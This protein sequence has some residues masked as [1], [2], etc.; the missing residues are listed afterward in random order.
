M[1]DAEGPAQS[2]QENRY[3]EFIQREK[4]AQMVLSRTRTQTHFEI[5]PPSFWHALPSGFRKVSVDSRRYDELFAEMQ[6]FR[7]RVYL[8]D[9]AIQPN[10]LADGR[11]KLNLDEHSWHVLSL[12]SS[13]RICAC[14]RFLEEPN[15]SGFD[16]LWVREAELAF[17]PTQ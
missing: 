12:D 8:S 11:H 3:S 7:G 14:A 16:D 17:S 1:R 10:E 5:L 13:G 4:A 2:P 9:G 6:R 15:A